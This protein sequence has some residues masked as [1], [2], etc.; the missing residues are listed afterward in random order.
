M[1]RNSP[2]FSTLLAA[3]AGAALATQPSVAGPVDLATVPLISGLSRVVPP[4][5]YF[6]LDD[7]TSMNW[8]FVPDSAWS[9]ATRRCFKNHGFNRAYYNP[10]ITYVPPKRA[11]GTSYPNAT[12]SSAWV[13]GYSTSAGTVNLGSQ[14]RAYVT[15]DNR[16]LASSG[17][18][19]SSDSAQAAYYFRHN[20]SPSSPPASCDNDN[21][22]T[23]VTL[24]AV[25]AEAQNFANWYSYYRTRLLTMKSSAGRAF[26]AV[27]GDFRVGFATIS[28][29]NPRIASSKFLKLDR[30]TATH[31]SNWYSKLYGSGCPRDGGCG[32]PLRGALSKAGQ[33]YA[34]TVLTG[35]D[36]PVQYSCQQNFTILT[37]DGYW[38]T[39]DETS[40]YGPKRLDNVTNVGDQDGISGTPRP[41][42]EAGRY[43]NT[44]ADIAMFYYRTDLR[45]AAGVG[46]LTDDG[47]RVDVS[48]NNVP[49]AGADNANWQHMT[50]FTLGLGVSGTLGYAENY[51][52]GGS[53][54]YNG[55]LQGT[56]NWPNPQTT[57]GSAQI[58][59]RVDDLWHAAVNGRGQYLSAS[60]PDTLVSA[61][62]KTLAAIS[63][64][65][66]SAAAAATS[67]L[68]PVAGDNYAY[69]AQYTTAL[70]YGDLLAREI[71]LATGA[72]SSTA[73]W[74]ARDLLSSKVGQ[75]SDSRQIYTFAP[76]ASDR[77]KDFDSANLTAEK[78][79]G[80][81][82]SGS[83]N[84]N[85]ALTQASGWTSAQQSAATDDAMIEFL[86]GW[87]RYE[88]EATNAT[89]LFR[90]RT[91]VLGDIVNAAP[92]YVRKPP[93]RYADSGYTQFVADN[94]DREATVYVGAN[95]GMLHA[96]DADTGAER[97]AY[98][99]SAVIPA[100]YRLADS[101]YANNHRFY[102]DGPITVGDVTDG[103]GWR[104]I[105]VGGLGRGGKAFYALDITDPDD[106]QG[107]WE[108]GTAQDADIGYSYGNPI[109]T[110]R[111]SDGKWVVILTSG[112][113][114]SGGD[115]KGRL[116]VLDAVTG[117]KLAEIVSSD[118]VTDPDQSGIARVT[119]WVLDTLVD[120]STTYVYGG[121][122]SGALWR[123]DI[124]AE[125]AQRL[126]VTS[127]TPGDQ[128]ITV[129][130]EVAQVRDGTG[131]YYR[132]IYFGTGRYLGF[133]DL[134]AAAPSS[135]VA[136]GIY[137]VKDTGSDLGVLTEPGAELVAQALDTSVTP[138][139]I[140]S[141]VAVD[142]QHDN[143][144]YVTLPVGERV[145]VDLKLQLGTLAVVS[146]EPDDDYCTVGGRSWLYALDYRTGGAVA[147]QQAPYASFPIGQSIAT[148]VTLVR[149]PTNKLVA[150]VTQ[151]DTTIRAMSLPV[152][153]G[154]AAQV[155]RVGWRE[156]D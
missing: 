58:V 120:N 132:V 144:W 71:D 64:S 44:L 32:T 119:N 35:N 128:P 130:P 142:W 50:T 156:I 126:G 93:F 5:I 87:S 18:P 147:G 100:M 97:W 137:A 47:T 22:Y 105:L 6:I 23:R 99:P 68:E 150:I 155:R 88:D 82:R 1:K 26:S 73:T 121:D 114:N 125:A 133:G 70:W 65:N 8:E 45:A 25:S 63:V 98:V 69:V 131:A 30:F 37:T 138:R 21:R 136:Q 4:N 94:A 43:A 76:L 106:P 79:A 139:T 61:L 52:S 53:A 113:D 109:I 62:S 2:R 36:D 46:G 145:N 14:F 103:S 42:F 153:P 72:L 116:Y 111:R 143:G 40:S 7:S 49:A 83:S 12:F 154:A 85:G 27:T 127:A 152:A 104:T 24:S 86:R 33:L 115:S 38:N 124:V 148:G 90:D 54:D 11:D 59:E 16:E 17:G 3:A 56:R 141:T 118:S 80:Y 84:P 135:A 110:K 57:S 96:F 41:F 67:S 112:Y 9:S 48:A 39:G 66:A 91:Y 95:D 81:F 151:S 75:N 123:F 122:L 102:V 149:L 92:V 101:G 51:L 15:G 117:Q 78:A 20:S 28:E 146:N 74:S 77:L 29:S 19:G 108:F 60:S 55:I 89:R 134:A 10:A 107:L 129:R 31:R 34:G 13:N 140:P